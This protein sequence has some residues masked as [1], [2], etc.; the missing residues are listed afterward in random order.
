MSDGLGLRLMRH[1]AQLLGGQLDLSHA[2][3][4][5]TLVRCRVPNPISS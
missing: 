5:G 2:P 3:A 4:G 1:R